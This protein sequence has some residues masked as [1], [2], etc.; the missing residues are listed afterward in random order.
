[1][2]LDDKFLRYDKLKPG[3]DHDRYDWSMLEQ[4][5]A[6]NWPDDKPLALW[7]NVSI[8]HFP[9]NPKGLGFK[10]PGNM[11]MPYP[12]LRHYSLRDYGNR[13]GIF[14]ILEAL[15]RF[16]LTAS[17]AINGEVAR[18]YP[19]L[20]RRLAGR[21]EILAHGWN[22]DSVHAAGVDESTERQWIN[23]TLAALADFCSDPI[24]GWLGPA[25]SQSNRTPELLAEAGIHWCADWVNDELPYRFRTDHGPL[26][27]L[28]LSLELE[29]RF[30]IGDNLH[31]ETE[32]GDQLIDAADFLLAEAQALGHG[33][34][35]TMNL[36]P[37]VIGQPHRIGQLE[38]VFAHLADRRSEMVN[39]GPSGLL[40]AVESS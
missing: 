26:T 14:R 10:A 21:G 39:L 30:V 18:R 7:I 4:R 31:S 23:D 6:L 40:A 28:P 32:Y 25:R 17:F 2:S 38:R 35:L 19:Y 36:H 9:L 13:V 20:V 34:L 29:D 15:E 12:D 24:R 11:T 3:M 33:R 37:W 27:H 1:M 5:P 8:E 16:D 22:M